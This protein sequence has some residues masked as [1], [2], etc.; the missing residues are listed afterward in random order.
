MAMR[1]RRMMVSIASICILG[2]PVG[3]GF[4]SSRFGLSQ[5]LGQRRKASQNLGFWTHARRLQGR[6]VHAEN[7]QS[8]A[9]EVDVH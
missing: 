7:A 3:Q 2:L 5:R 8:A 6:Y 1:A 9:S 4:G